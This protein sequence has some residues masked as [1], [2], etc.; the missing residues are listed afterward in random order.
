MSTKR[1]ST[2]LT[3]S[4]AKHYTIERSQSESSHTS[5]CWERQLDKVTATLGNGTYDHAIA[6]VNQALDAF[7]LQATRMVRLRAHAWGRKGDLTREMRDAMLIVEW[8][9]RSPMSYLLLSDIYISHGYQQQAIQVLEKG[10]DLSPPQSDGYAKLQERKAFA[11]AKQEKRIDIVS[12]APYDIFCKISSYFATETL[13]DC[14]WVSRSWHNKFLECSA[15]WKDVNLTKLPTRP[16][17]FLPRIVD[18]VRNLCLDESTVK[19][20]S[21][22]MLANRFTNMRTLHLELPRVS[23]GRFVELS[24]ALEPAI[25]DH[26][27]VFDRVLDVLSNTAQSLTGIVIN[28]DRCIT[29]PRLPVILSGCR[30]LTSIEYRC[31]GF[32]VFTG[33]SL[34]FTTS[35]RKIHLVGIIQQAELEALLRCSPNI[36]YIRLEGCTYDAI[37]VIDRVPLELDYI[38]IN[39]GEQFAHHPDEPGDTTLE[40]CHDGL[41]TL[42]VDG[43]TSPLTIISLL[44]RN[45]NSLKTLYLSCTTGQMQHRMGSLNTNWNDVQAFPLMTKLTTL[46]T[47]DMTFDLWKHIPNILRNCPGLQT[48]GIEGE[49]VYDGVVVDPVVNKIAQMI[50]FSNLKLLNTD[51]CAE[52][53]QDLLDGLKQ[54]PLKTLV[55]ADIQTDSSSLIRAIDIKSLKTLTVTWKHSHTSLTAQDQYRFSRVIAGL[56]NLES[57][58]LDGFNHFDDNAI[59]N[60]CLSKSLK[61]VRFHTVRG[62]TKT[63]KNKLRDRLPPIQLTIH[64]VIYKMYIV[65]VRR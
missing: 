48:F 31:P 46:H 63:A 58:T 61:S 30:N 65:P 17:S 1:D 53:I 10:L 59:D 40:N 18:N 36:R 9:P 6:M 29:G 11:Q 25:S 3:P 55:M 52:P 34:P 37:S 57:L 21:T 38:S 32:K 56:P 41:Q 8:A 28:M 50:T 12:Q 16:S 49:R 24:K 45:R 4:V 26:R 64:P 39:C 54:K 60:L 47:V 7:L 13:S 44:E 62:Y 5:E 27:K 23:P 20:V 19:H 22:L 35:L 51:I 33:L 2:D 15:L 14:I 42:V 43:L